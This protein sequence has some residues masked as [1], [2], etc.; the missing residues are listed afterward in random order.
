MKITGTI[1]PYGATIIIT[2]SGPPKYLATLVNRLANYGAVHTVDEDYKEGVDHTVRLTGRKGI[3][4][5]GVR[6][7]MRNVLLA[8]LR[9]KMN[10]RK[11]FIPSGLHTNGIVSR[12]KKMLVA[13][14]EEFM[15]AL[16]PQSGM[17][18]SQSKRHAGGV[19][20]TSGDV[21]GKSWNEHD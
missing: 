9:A 5:A 7:M 21:Q 20:S 8:R 19:F 11:T 12:F 3:F 14:V 2:L 16:E 1:A 10:P 17:F 18:E 15:S 6:A 4:E 13:N